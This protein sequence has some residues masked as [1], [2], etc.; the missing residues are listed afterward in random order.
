MNTRRLNEDCLCIKCSSARA[1]NLTKTLMQWPIRY[2]CEKCGNKRCPHHS[3]HA[4]KCTGSNKPGQ[5]G[6]IYK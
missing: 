1:R 5:K 2:A 6:S 3:D 4:L